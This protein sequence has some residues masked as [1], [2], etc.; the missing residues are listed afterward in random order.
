MALWKLQRVCP[1]LAGSIY[2]RSTL[3]YPILASHFSACHAVPFEVEPMPDR[4]AEASAGQAPA[5][6]NPDRPAG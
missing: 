4:R 6:Y 5:G 1:P 3:H 2:G